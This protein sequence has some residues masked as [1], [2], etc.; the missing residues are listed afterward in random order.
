MV[1]ENELLQSGLRSVLAAEPW[2]ASC[3]TAT[4]AE[5][6]WHVAQRALPQLV[7]VSMSLGGRSSLDLCRMF[8]DRMPHVRVVL[9]S[10]EGR[11]T[12]AVAQLHG[13]VAAL[14][15][16]MP[17]Q[18]IIN[19]LLRVTEGAKI[20]PKDSAACEKRLSPREL[21]VL[22]HVATGLSNPEVATALCLSRHTVKQHTT[23]IYR[24]LDVRNR[25]QAASRAQ[26]LGLLP[27]QD[28]TRTTGR[29]TSACAPEI[30]DLGTSHA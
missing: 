3:L 19:A 24:K 18:F 11:I 30:T 10:S 14:S 2:V 29:R 4:S 5:T 26:E 28:R 13:A 15:K 17:R 20:F 23:A 8:R 22:R 12:G 9:M 21:D 16:Q 1:D 25:A 27:A 7:L 6:A